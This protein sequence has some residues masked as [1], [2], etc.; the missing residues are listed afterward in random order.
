[1]R[2]VAGQMLSFIDDPA[3]V[4]EERSYRFFDRGAVA[5]D[6]GGQIAWS[7]PLADLPDDWRRTAITDHGRSLILPGFI[8]AHLHFPQ[9]RMIAAYGADL[10]DWLNRYTFVEEQR[11]GDPALAAQA[12]HAFLDELVRNGVTAC[13]AFS[14]VHPEAL[15]ALFGE[16]ERRNM[17]VI[18]GK[19]MMDCNAPRGLSDTPESGYLRSKELIARWHGRGRLQYAI[20]PRFAVTSSEAQ[21]EATGALKREHPDLVLQTHLSENKAE[22]EA[23][24]RVF[25]WSCDYTDVYDRYGLLSE[26]AFFAHGIHLSERELA[27][28][29]E[30]GAAIAHCPTSNNFLGSGLFGYRHAREATRP[31]S[32]AI[33]SDIGGGTSF[34]MLATLRDAY[35]VSQLA[36]ARI[37]AFDAFYL[38]TL[39]NARLLHIDHEIGS[40]DPGRFADLVVLDPEATPVM[41]A[42]H[43]LSASLHDVL[44]ALIIMGDDRAVAETYV[45]GRPMKSVL[46][47]ADNA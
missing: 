20:S 16:A 8:D 40:L 27:R 35:V 19:T 1:M 23:V 15:D 4:G 46:A 31:V 18:S 26:R 24:A 22:I 28:L 5:I 47:T 33:G 32:V 6:D 9:Y 42:R 29:S 39:G 43:A 12:A 17:A 37:S 7:G 25:P 44:F 10:L 41:A 30:T 36:G 38:A 3:I 13:L 21:L 11:Y 34:S 45:A 2:V 14:T